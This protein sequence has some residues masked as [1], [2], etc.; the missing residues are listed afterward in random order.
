MNLIT[1][2]LPIPILSIY[3]R[4]RQQQCSSLLRLLNRKFT[5]DKGNDKNIRNHCQTHGLT[6][7]MIGLVKKRLFC[8]LF[9]RK[10]S[11]RQYKRER[12]ISRV[13]GN[14]GSESKRINYDN[15]F[16]KRKCLLCLVQRISLKSLPNPDSQVSPTSNPEEGKF[17][18]HCK[19]FRIRQF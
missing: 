14:C 2:S 18:T 3:L 5:C 10:N 16:F 9:P 17:P 6:I 7:S 11:E 12:K 15:G 4:S 13:N 19:D 1:T 8:N